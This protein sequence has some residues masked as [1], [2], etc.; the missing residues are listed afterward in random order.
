MTLKSTLQQLNSKKWRSFLKQHELKG[1]YYAVSPLEELV[2][3]AEVLFTNFT[4]AYNLSF[5]LADHSTC[6]NVCD[7]S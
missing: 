2:T 1:I 5:L 4:T 6:L 3:R 7:V